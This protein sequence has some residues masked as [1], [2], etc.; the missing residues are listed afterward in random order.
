M[1]VWQFAAAVDG[2]VKAHDANSDNRM[3]SAEKDE[4]WE[5]VKG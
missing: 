4:V 1:S 3:T 2:W 5:L